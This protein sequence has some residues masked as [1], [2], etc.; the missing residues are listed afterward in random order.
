MMSSRPNEVS[1]NSSDQNSRGGAWDNVPN[2]LVEKEMFV[3]HQHRRVGED[4]SDDRKRR[5][6]DDSFS[7]LSGEERSRPIK[8]KLDMKITKRRKQQEDA[9]AMATNR[10]NMTGG[11][12]SSLLGL[13]NHQTTV[14]FVSKESVPVKEPKK[15]LQTQ[16]DGEADKNEVVGNMD[17]QPSPSSSTSDDNRRLHGDET[18]GNLVDPSVSNKPIIPLNAEMLNTQEILAKLLMMASAAAASGNNGGTQAVNSNL[19]SN[20]SSVRHGLID[21]KK[22]GT[23]GIVSLGQSEI[24]ETKGNTEPTTRN[25]VGNHIS[26]LSDYAED[27]GNHEDLDEDDMNSDLNYR[28]HSSEDGSRFVLN[29]GMTSNK[30]HTLS[31]SRLCTVEGQL[32]SNPNMSREEAKEAAK[33]EYNRR[34][35]ARARVRNKDMVK[36]LQKRVN[37][38]THMVTQLQRTNDVLR[39]QIDVMSLSSSQGTSVPTGGI[40]KNLASPSSDTKNVGLNMLSAASEALPGRVF[41][42]SLPIT[43]AKSDSNV[44]HGALVSLTATDLPLSKKEPMMLGSSNK[45]TESM[46]DTSKSSQKLDVAQKKIVSND[47]TEAKSNAFAAPSIQAQLSTE[48]QPT[49]MN[50]SVTNS[51]GRSPIVDASNMT[52]MMSSLIEKSMIQGQQQAQPF[53]PGL[54]F[55]QF[56]QQ[57]QQQ[58]QFVSPELVLAQ[59]Q[60]IQNMLAQSQQPFIGHVPTSMQVP[61]SG[62]V[63]T[64]TPA[65][66]GSSAPSHQSNQNHQIN[67]QIS[68]N[69]APGYNGNNMVNAA[70]PVAA[71]PLQQLLEAL[72][73][74]NFH[75]LQQQGFLTGM[76]NPNLAAMLNPNLFSTIAPQMQQQVQQPNQGTT[77][78]NSNS[79]MTHYPNSTQVQQQQATPA[80]NASSSTINQQSGNTQ[81]LQVLLQSGGLTPETIFTLMREQQQ[82]QQQ[83]T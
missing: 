25:V 56:Q 32:A 57:Q 55:Y 79:H 1:S 11:D 62:T 70:A 29:C 45:G 54:P 19:V 6:E 74:S 2:N 51:F 50:N 33:K 64:G 35:A 59:I 60:N 82:Q 37:E 78:H 61:P 75:Q 12:R 68:G 65:L 77:C 16:R 31:S 14:T 42:S 44:T 53:L 69:V 38:L 17:L 76:A 13:E 24:N 28:T 47:A 7:S 39:S 41:P 22:F 43:A 26:C 72:A 80:T 40:N 8:S 21:G 67:S 66:Q 81:T 23:S 18:R 3:H 20:M 36:S 63:V 9:A 34:N 10:S 48:Q 15:E 4:L 73:A 58:Q 46:L 30:A 27:E 49:S 52:N 83:K 5:K 71:P